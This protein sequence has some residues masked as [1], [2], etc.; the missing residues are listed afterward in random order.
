MRGKLIFRA[1]VTVS[2]KMR[3]FGYL[4]IAANGFF[5][6]IV[7]SN[8]LLQT[9]IVADSTIFQPSETIALSLL[10][11][12][13]FI[14]KTPFHCLLC[15]SIYLLIVSLLTLRAVVA[16]YDVVHIEG[17]LSNCGNS[18]LNILAEYPF[19][20]NM[21]WFG[22]VF[23]KQ[24]T[25]YKQMHMVRSDFKSNDVYGKFFCLFF[26]RLFKRDAILPVKTG[27]LLRGIQ[28]KW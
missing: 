19:K 16:K 25:I 8:P 26:Y 13:G 6:M 10:V 20:R 14:E 24:C 9:E 2:S 18:S 21:I 15:A 3:E 27:L 17:S 28:T 11:Y 4:V 1:V 7:N 5:S 12:I 22:A 23:G